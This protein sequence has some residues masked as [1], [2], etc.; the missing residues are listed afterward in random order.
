MPD[1]IRPAFRAM[2]HCRIRPLILCAML[3]ITYELVCDR[4]GEW[5]AISLHCGFQGA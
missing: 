4:K 5:D 2:R 1:G 3:Q